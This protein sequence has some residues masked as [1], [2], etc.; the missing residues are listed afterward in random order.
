MKRILLPFWV[1]NL[2]KK[3]YKK[4]KLTKRMSLRGQPLAQEKKRRKEERKKAV[5]RKSY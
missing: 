1:R 2:P 5:W 3:G 4:M